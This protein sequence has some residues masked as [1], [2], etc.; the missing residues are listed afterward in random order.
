[1]LE[2][3]EL[4]GRDKPVVTG[5]RPHGFTVGERR[6]YGG[7][8]LVPEGYVEIAARRL[9]DIAAEELTALFDADPDIEILLLGGGAQLR[10]PPDGL[11]RSLDA[12]GIAVEP[13]DS[14]AA[15]RTFNV[16]I[17]EERRVAALLLPVG[18][19]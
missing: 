18:E 9:D 19:G 15:A 10:H 17:M 7:L 4:T 5:Y 16:L 12:A 2:L 1:M 13:M 11:R 8:L 6:L 3:K 14:A